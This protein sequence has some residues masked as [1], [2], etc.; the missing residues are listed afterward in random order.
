MA[1]TQ[2]KKE[3]HK[4]LMSI[5]GSNP[6]IKDD[7]LAGMLKVSVATIRTDRREL[8][9]NEYRE[10]VQKMAKNAAGKN[11]AEIVDMELFHDGVS[12]VE[13]K[14]VATYDGTDIIKG[15]EMFGIAENLALN[16]INT[17]KALICVANVK[18]IKEVHKGERLVAK[19]EVVRTKNSEYIVWVKMRMNRVEVFRSKFKLSVKE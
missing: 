14:D 1:R 18:Y 4:K 11:P 13:T 16:I 12:I 3:R 10:R 19:I 7:E 8:G 6:F 2:M 15:Q 9:I 5:I 17:N